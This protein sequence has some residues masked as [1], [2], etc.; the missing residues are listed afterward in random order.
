MGLMPDQLQVINKLK[1]TYTGNT[2]YVA[3]SGG[4]DSMLLL[5]LLIQAELN[6]IALHVNYGLRQEESDLDQA[7]VESFVKKREYVVKFIVVIFLS[8]AGIFN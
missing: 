1:K 8:I 4:V 3:C 2:C 6:P 7:L 5:Y